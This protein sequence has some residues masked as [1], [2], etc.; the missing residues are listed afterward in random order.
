ML[1]AGG[2]GLPL[3]EETHAQGLHRVRHF[4]LAWSQPAW[5]RCVEPRP[6]PRFS[7]AGFIIPWSEHARPKSRGIPPFPNRA[8]MPAL[9]R[10]QGTAPKGVRGRESVKAVLSNDHESPLGMAVDRD[11]LAGADHLCP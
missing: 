9:C 10:C 5:P 11:L 3:H 4:F 1:N 7:D 6:W 2:S 8:S